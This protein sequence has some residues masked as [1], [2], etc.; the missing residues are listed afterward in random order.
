MYKVLIVDDEM[1]IRQGLTALV[2]SF[3]LDYCVV[4][5]AGN[6]ME[7]SRKYQMHKPDVMII[8]I[9]M[10]GQSGLELIE[11]LRAHDPAL[12][13]IILSGYADFNYAKTAITFGIDHYLLKP[14]DE[15][16]LRECLCTILAKLDARKQQNKKQAAL[17]GWSREML[18]Q[19]LLMEDGG[20]AL[21]SPGFLQEA[22]LVWEHYQ[23]MLI[24][25][26]HKDQMDIGYSTAVKTLLAASFEEQ[27]WGIV[28]SLDSHLGVVVHP[29]VQNEYLRKKV[30]QHIR[31]TVVAGN[32]QCVIAA[33]DIVSMATDLPLSY[34]TALNRMKDH[35]F[36]DDT[37]IIGPDSLKLKQDHWLGSEELEAKLAVVVDR[38]YFAMDIGNHLVFPRLIQE[39]GDLMISARYSE[40]AIKS[41]YVRIVTSL[42]NKL[43]LHDKEAESRH[44]QINEQIQYIFRHTSLVELQ[45]Y[46]SALL[47]GFNSLITRD[48]TDVIMK[49]MIDLIKR[50]YAENLKLETLADVFSYSSAY[51]GKLFKNHSGLSFN[52]YLEKVRMEKAMELLNQGYKVHQAAS[53][54]GFTDVDYFREKFKKVAGVSPSDYRK[55]K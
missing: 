10:P 11:E 19:S 15:D 18:V 3:A 35:F 34:Q 50:R 25:L 24:Q 16:E 2:E 5:T 54:V 53:E 14:V 29:S 27:G 52:S 42:H 33:G 47:E 4:D 17:H 23:V 48:E 28:F 32:Y 44:S 1:A 13:M 49:R 8:D 30:V 40:L 21:S 43:T 38:L 22:G 12:H 41:R 37:D 36:Y 6:A 31:E 9:R 55:T 45:R 46:I 26:F 51:L 39:A 7:A 20:P